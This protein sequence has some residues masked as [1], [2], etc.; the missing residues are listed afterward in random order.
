MTGVKW[1][2]IVVLICMSLIISDVEHLFMCLFAICISSLEKMSIQVFCL[3][4]DWVVCFFDIELYE[5]FTYFGYYPL[6]DCIFENIF[7]KSVGFLF[8]LLM[9][10]FPGQKILRL[11]LIVYSPCVCS[12][13]VFLCVVDFQFHTL[14]LEKMLDIIF[15]LLNLLRLF[16]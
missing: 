10:S 12:C 8:A 2:L 7:S 15:I 11:K 9:V 6:I 4:F 14:W 1:Q 5:L 3:F 13:P 16:W